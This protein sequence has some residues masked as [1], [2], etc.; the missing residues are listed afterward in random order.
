MQILKF[1]LNH[2]KVTIFRNFFRKGYLTVKS[3]HMYVIGLLSNVIKKCV[4]N[5]VLKR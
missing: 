2:F 5:I 4:K 3:C 1:E